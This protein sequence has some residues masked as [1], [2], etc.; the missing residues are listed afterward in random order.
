[1]SCGLGHRFA[2]ERRHGPPCSTAPPRKVMPLGGG[3]SQGVASRRRYWSTPQRPK[4]KR[5]DVPV[6]N[7]RQALR[8]DLHHCYDS[9]MAVPDMSSLGLAPV[10]S[11]AQAAEILRNLGLEDLTECAL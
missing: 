7:A 11:P 10:Y 6:A 2:C 1:M 5:A 3:H 4:N 8:G 9:C